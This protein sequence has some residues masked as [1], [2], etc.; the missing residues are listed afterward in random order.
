VVSRPLQVG[1]PRRLGSYE[2]LERLGEGG[3]AVVFLGRASSGGRVAIKLLK[4]SLAASDN[5]RIRFEREADAARRVAGLGYTAQVLDADVAGDRPYIVSEYIEGLSLQQL[6]AE[7]GPRPASGLMTL[8]FAT[9]KALDAI[10]RA[11]IVHRD[12]KP[13]N[14]LMSPDGPRVVDFGIARILDTATTIT[15]GIIGTPAYMAPEQ[16]SHA[17][18]TSKTDV[19]AWGALITYAA[20]GRP[21]FGTADDV[22]YRVLHLDP[23]LGSL[24]G[25]LRDLVAACLAKEPEPR[26]TA[27]DILTRLLDH[28]EIVPAGT[29]SDGAAEAS[30][31][32]QS[33]RGGLKDVPATFHPQLAAGA[34]PSVDPPSRIVSPPPI[35]RMAEHAGESGRAIQEHRHDPG[36]QTNPVLSN[37]GRKS[38]R[39]G[40]RSLPQRRQGRTRLIL[41][42]AGILSACGVACIIPG[43]ALFEREPILGGG[44]LWAGSGVAMAGMIIFVVHDR[45]SYRRRLI[46]AGGSRPKTQG[47]GFIWQ[48]APGSQVATRFSFPSTKKDNYG[49]LVGR[50]RL[51]IDDVGDNSVPTPTVEWVVAAGS[52]ELARGEL[53]TSGESSY[54]STEGGA[55]RFTNPDGTCAEL[56]DVNFGAIAA[57]SGIQLTIRHTGESAHAASVHWV[58]PGI[59]VD[60]NPAKSSP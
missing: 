14:V 28:E 15:S 36:N 16:V 50:L 8:A 54:I 49:G 23:E 55:R 3:Q 30:P 47:K 10:H 37:S 9:A 52:A 5:P 32:P 41:Q 58:K 39:T 35:G 2:L 1:D 51:L 44:L 59:W 45:R 21:P 11:G 18:I 26:P 13:H 46:F 4:D 22:L 24:S 34:E 17:E 19:F 29:A 6:V 53:G 31:E 12:L 38:L 48:L 40:S 56:S 60:D 57:N 7:S 25:P 42:V 27:R 33:P 43:F 20:T